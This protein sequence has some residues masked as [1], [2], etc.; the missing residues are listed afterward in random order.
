MDPSF[1][2]APDRAALNFLFDQR[3]KLILEP[4]PVLLVGVAEQCSDD[5]RTADC[6]A[7]EVGRIL[8]DSLKRGDR[9]GRKTMGFDQ[10]WLGWFFCLSFFGCH[11]VS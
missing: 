7:D 9:A 1:F 10:T 8:S 5:S 4:F 3:K 2:P 11:K 6:P